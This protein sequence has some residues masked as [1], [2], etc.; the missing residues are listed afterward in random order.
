MK[1]AKSEP[2]VVEPVFKVAEAKQMK[3]KAVEEKGN[4]VSFVC[5]N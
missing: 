4:N 2:E 3:S 5:N 1:A